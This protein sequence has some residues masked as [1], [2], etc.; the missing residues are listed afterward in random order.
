MICII[1][2]FVGA[3]VIQVV[4][5][6]ARNFVE[7]LDVKKSDETRLIDYHLNKFRHFLL[8][9]IFLVFITSEVF[10]SHE[11]ASNRSQGFISAFFIS[12]FK[13]VNFIKAI[14]SVELEIT[15]SFIKA[16]ND[17]H[18]VASRGIVINM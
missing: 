10:I 17:D 5:R 9:T 3:V 8:I 7:V 6:S 15:L 12:V 14:S 13:R 18:L 11:N 1:L 16:A 2:T 4:A